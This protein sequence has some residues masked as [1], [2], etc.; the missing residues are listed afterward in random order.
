MDLYT[1][2][3]ADSGDPN[4]VQTDASIQEK[5]MDTMDQWDLSKLEQ[6]V[7]SKHGKGIPTS[8]DIV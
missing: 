8:T 5:E 2:A 7:T 6:V 3:R 4:S 1:D